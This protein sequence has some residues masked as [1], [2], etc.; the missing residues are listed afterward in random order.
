MKPKAQSSTPQIRDSSLDLSITSNKPAGEHDWG[1]E[2]DG[3]GWKQFHTRPCAFLQVKNGMSLNQRQSK[4]HM[5]QSTLLLS[6]PTAGNPTALCA[7][8]QPWGGKEQPGACVGIFCQ[9]TKQWWELWR[10]CWKRLSLQLFLRLL[11]SPWPHPAHRR[12]LVLPAP[13][14]LLFKRVKPYPSGVYKDSSDTVELV[15]HVTLIALAVCSLLPAC[16]CAPVTEDACT[17]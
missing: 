11:R 14:L 13:F 1:G 7:C 12:C 5:R 4:A 9:R 16:M 10:A 15:I 17:C 8:P 3:L 2:E 6:T